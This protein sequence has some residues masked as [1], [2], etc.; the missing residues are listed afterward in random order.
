MVGCNCFSH[1]KPR[2]LETQGY[3][4]LGRDLVTAWWC[5]IRYGWDKDSGVF[6]LAVR[7]YVFESWGDSKSVNGV[8]T[9][10]LVVKQRVLGV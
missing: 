1:G 6:C 2:S 10:C 5:P 8:L 3:S 4:G 9:L 7:V